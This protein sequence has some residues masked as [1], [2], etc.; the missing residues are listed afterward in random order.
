MHRRSARHWPRSRPA[1]PRCSTSIAPAPTPATST[2]SSIGGRRNDATYCVPDRRAAEL[3]AAART[4]SA[5]D[6][7]GSRPDRRAA[8]LCAAAPTANAN[9]H[10]GSRPDRRAAELC[11]AAPTANPMNDLLSG[12]PL[13]TRRRGTVLVVDD[14]EGVRASIRAILEETCEVLEAEHGAAALEILAQREVDLVMLDQRMPGEAGVDILPRVKAL[15]PSVVVVIATAVRDVRTAVEALK[16]GAYDY[17]IKPFDVD[18]IIG[19]AD[20]VLEKRDLEREVVSL[21]S[22]LAG[23]DVEASVGFEGLVG[24]HPEMAR[25]YQL[26]TQIAPTP[27]T[28][29][30]TGESGT[31][32]EL[33][34]RAIH[35]RSDRQSAPFV[36]VN[37]AAIPE[38]LI[39]SELFG[40]ERGAFTGAHARRLGRFELAHGGTVFLDEIGSLRLDLQSKLLRVLQEREIER[41]GGQR[42]VPV[43]VR[44]LAATNANLRA[45]VRERAF[46]EDLFYRLNVVPLHLPPLRERREDIPHLVEHFI[47]KAARECRRDVRGVSVGALE[48]LAR[49]DWPGNVREL[50][51]V[52]HRAVVLAAGPVLHLQDVPLDVAMPE[53]GARLTEDDGL[54]LREAC[55][56]FERQYVL[57]VLERVQWNVS[58]AAR[59]L[60]VHRNTVLAKLSTWGVQRPGGGEGR[61]ASL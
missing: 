59:L 11:A 6:H 53:T 32:K 8:E 21:R 29:L 41:V 51:N 56:R 52:I 35:R 44:V 5:N 58:R 27:T 2:S 57:R 33:V 55:D 26:I 61:S 3:C 40:H 36:A 13:T 47:R 43:D 19:L 34:A 14:E 45:A 60:G 23:G 30:I 28:V 22:A 31:G 24:R 10:A 17:L 7:A 12:P 42:P 4:A 37:V 20:R 25:L 16:R 39:E 54:P 38:T 1:R 9:D 48:V 18:D 15:D 50:E 49:Y 46:R